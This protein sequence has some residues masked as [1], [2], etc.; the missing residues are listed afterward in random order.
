MHKTRFAPGSN[1]SP[2]LTSVVV[3]YLEIHRRPLLTSQMRFSAATPFVGRANS[4]VSPPCSSQNAG[5]FR[6]AETF[7]FG[8]KVENTEETSDHYTTLFDQTYLFFSTA[9]FRTIQGK[10]ESYSSVS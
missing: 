4:C 5:Y 3:C 10:F 1:D 6:R 2:L 9:F 7:S 8:T